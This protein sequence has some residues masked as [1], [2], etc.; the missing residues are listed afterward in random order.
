ME[1]DYD[2]GELQLDSLLATKSKID[3]RFVLTGLEILKHKN[4]DE[5]F[6]QVLQNLDNETL[7][8]LCN[9]PVL[10]SAATKLERCK[11]FNYE[12][13]NPA[14]QLQLIKM[15][16]NDQIS[17]SGNMDAI[18]T[19]YK[20]TKEE[21]VY[22]KDNMSTDAENRKQLKEIFAKYGFPTRKMV[23][24][25][26]MQGIF[27]IIQHADADKEWQQAQLP[28]VENAVKKGDMDGQRYAY[29]YDRI[30]INSGEKQLYGTQFAKVDPV[31][32]VAELALTED[33]ENL[34]KRRMGMGMM[35]IETYK[36]IM[37]KSVSK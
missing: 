21:V 29:L 12:A 23:G 27:F 22:G 1:K 28:K 9:K 20:L 32:K 24:E 11:S 19:T 17:R 31:N 4:K 15:Y 7:E 5:K 8:F 26:A 18:I 3:K 35:P 2:L 25:D 14:L 33:L 6:K 10:S 36:V 34:D 13:D 30:K 16:I 37:L